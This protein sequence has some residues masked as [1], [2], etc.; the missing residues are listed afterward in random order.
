MPSS[1][2]FDDNPTVQFKYLL[3]K[4]N[5][6]EHQLAQKEI[7]S[8]SGLLQAYQQKQKELAIVMQREAPEYNLFEVLR[9]RHYE[10]KVHTPFLAHLLNPKANH[11][12]GRLFFDS[13]LASVL[14]QP[15][16]A[17]QVK[18][19]KILSERR[20]AFG[21]I[22]IEIWYR[23][24]GVQKAI[25]IENKIY[26]HDGEAQLHRYYRYLTENKK[27]FIPD[28]QIVYLTLEGR[29]PSQNSL[30]SVPV[31]CLKSISYRSD[32]ASWL[33]AVV[34]GLEPNPVFYTIQQY[35]KTINSL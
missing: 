16:N 10:A 4:Y 25:V 3:Q 12:Q 22:D 26:H 14:Q 33:S 11:Q 30:G 7:A 28:V 6:F 9:I 19:I 17:E 8:L 1:E 18:D 27:I 21:Q 24:Q 32:I 23:Q 29:E 35:L 2:V 34:K 13:F 5:S 20:N 15:C 31:E